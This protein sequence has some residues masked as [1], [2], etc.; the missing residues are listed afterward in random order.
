MDFKFYEM[1]ISKHIVVI[2]VHV[3]TLW[4]TNMMLPSVYVFKEDSPAVHK[5]H[6][7][8]DKKGYDVSM[9]RTEY[10]A[11]HTRFPI[12]NYRNHILRDCSVYQ[13]IL[14]FT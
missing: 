5:H 12:Y 10:T 8:Y 4:K 7:L 3:R 14:R 9:G 13:W 6:A 1:C 2:Y 11:S